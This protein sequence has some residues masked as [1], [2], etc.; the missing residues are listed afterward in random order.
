MKF[1]ETYLFIFRRGLRR[2][3]LAG[4]ES[5][6]CLQDQ[7]NL[8]SER[9]D[10]LETPTEQPSEPEVPEDVPAPMP[11]VIPVPPVVPDEPTMDEPEPQPEEPTEPAPDVP[12]EEP[13]DPVEEP[14]APEEPETPENPPTE[15]PNEPV[16]EPTEPTEPETPEE[17]PE[18][19]SEPETP[20]PEPQGL[21]WTKVDRGEAVTWCYDNA[22]S[23][24]ADEEVLQE[25]TSIYA[26]IEDLCSIRFER[27]FTDDCDIALKFYSEQAGGTLAFVYLPSSGSSV[28]ACPPDCGNINF[29][30]EES[31]WISMVDFHNICMHEAIHAIGASHVTDETSIMNPIFVESNQR[32]DI[33]KDAYVV[34]ELQLRYPV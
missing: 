27:V 31:Q 32:V 16:D 12:E 4:S 21:R 28:E 34:R 17:T 25:L 23:P 30:S 9:L 11:P 5:V 26:Q 19:P 29:D 14:E 15:E 24:Y 6:E 2:V 20:T 3:K 33:S 13:T 22:G 7:I 8:L 1:Y 10:A 18:A